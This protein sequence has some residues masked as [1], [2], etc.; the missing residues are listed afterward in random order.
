MNDAV[1]QTQQSASDVRSLD[2][3]NEKTF[4]TNEAEET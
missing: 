1:K 2:I 4:A 3:P